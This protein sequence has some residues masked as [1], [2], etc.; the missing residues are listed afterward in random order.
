MNDTGNEIETRKDAAKAMLPYKH[1]KMGDTVK[2]TQKRR[3]Q[4]SSQ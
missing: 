2:R 3:G 1:P 4:K